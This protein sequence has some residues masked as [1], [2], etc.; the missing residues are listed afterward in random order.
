[1][2][3]IEMTTQTIHEDSQATISIP[4]ILGEAFVITTEITWIAMA[5]S[6]Q[7]GAK[8][9]AAVDSLDGTGGPTAWLQLAIT[10]VNK[11]VSQLFE[12][13]LELENQLIAESTS[14]TSTDE[15]VVDS[16]T[17]LSEETDDYEKP[18]QFKIICVPVD[19][20]KWSA[21]Q[22]KQLA[23]TLKV[24]GYSS[25]TKSQLIQEVQ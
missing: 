6:F 23:K 3:T 10:K 25:M 16:S 1:M 8:V 11:R 13:Y 15:P 12:K 24:K 21:K 4:Q 7:A 22:L 5:A 19:E 9:R 17:I 20:Y 18:I 14:G 2:N